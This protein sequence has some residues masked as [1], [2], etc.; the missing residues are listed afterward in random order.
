MKSSW[1]AM[2]HLM[3]LINVS[4]DVE[5]DAAAAAAYP[6]G[7]NSGGRLVCGVSETLTMN[8]HSTPPIC[9][10]SWVKGRYNA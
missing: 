2:Q 3:S 5:S 9:D 8:A 4:S 6:Q 1:I 7:G 10:W